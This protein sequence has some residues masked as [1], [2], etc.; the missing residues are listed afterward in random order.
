LASW[1]RR[2]GRRLRASHASEQ[3]SDARVGEGSQIGA[4]VDAG[5]AK[6]CEAKTDGCARHI[7]E[8]EQVRGESDERFSCGREGSSVRR[9]ELEVETEAWGVVGG[10]ALA[11]A[12]LK[13]QHC[14]VAQSSVGGERQVVGE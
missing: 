10:G 5:A 7:A 2:G 3:A 4:A 13:K 14:R 6:C 11:Q 8:G 9:A 12:S 1:A